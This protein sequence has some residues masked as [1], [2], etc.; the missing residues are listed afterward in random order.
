MGMEKNLTIKFVFLL[1]HGA[2]NSDYEMYKC[3]FNLQEINVLRTQ[4]QKLL[5]KDKQVCG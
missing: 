2:H 4:V 3:I 1:W 5:H